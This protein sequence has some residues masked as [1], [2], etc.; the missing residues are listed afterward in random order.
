M[1]H[2]GAQDQLCLLKMDTI[3]KPKNINDK[4]FIQLVPSCI[5]SA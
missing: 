1:S 2:V 5:Q 3:Q 4:N